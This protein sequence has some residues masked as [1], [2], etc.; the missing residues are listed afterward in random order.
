M[1][2]L[3]YLV[4]IIC[5]LFIY[6]IIATNANIQASEEIRLL[7]NHHLENG[8]FTNSNGVANNKKF[9]ELIKWSVEKKETKVVP[10]NFEIIKPNYSIINKNKDAYGIT[11]IGHASFLYQN[12]ELN[13][14]T[15]PHLTERASPLS[16]MG[17]KRYM[18]PAME[19][20]ELPKINIVT[21]SHNHYDH[22]DLKTVKWIAKKNPDALFLVPLGLKKWFLNQSIINVI[23]LD[24][25]D[26]Y[27]KDNTTIT[28]TPVQHWSSRTLF[29]RNE[30]LWGGWHIKNN[31]HSLIHLGD[32]GYS[33]DFKETNK[34]L[35]PVDLALIPIGAYAPR[36]FMKFSHMNPSE[37]IQAFV[38]LEA[39]KAIGMHWGTFILT[40]EPV[41]EP[42]KVL[43]E[44]LK[45]RS[46]SID[47]FIVMKHGQTINLDD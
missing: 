36:W 8:T 41:D 47:D 40:D 2:T 29:D 22:L 1:L 35:G 12:N 14:L 43:K 45:K 30:S 38:D 27:T 4:N 44:E 19:L 39:K 3:K 20:E 34:R 37:A 7:P 13:I 42:P 24:W 32:T 23:E 25:W 26:E 28:F 11:W 31:H 9:K 10:I 21:I 17:P 46:I 6:L 18:R 15:D 33:N 5:L 16:F